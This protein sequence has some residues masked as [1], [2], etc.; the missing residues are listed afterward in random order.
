MNIYVKIIVLIALALYFLIAFVAWDL[1][2]VA[3]CGTAGR[4]AYLF[5]VTILSLGGCISVEEGK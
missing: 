5:F 4:F 1:M 2:W 3:T